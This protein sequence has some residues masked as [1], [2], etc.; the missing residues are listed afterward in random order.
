MFS[1]KMKS[2]TMIAKLVLALA[3]TSVLTGCSQEELALDDHYVPSTHYERYPIK[4]AK[5]PIKMEISSKFGSLQPSQINAISEFARS[6][7]SASASRIMVRRP[8]G[9]GASSQVA[10]QVAQLLATSGIPAS[11]ISYGTYP[12]SAKGPVQISYVRAVAVTKECGDW[13]SDVTNL[14]NDQLV[15]NLGCAIQNNYAAMVDN[16]EDFVVPRAT[17]PSAAGARTQAVRLY[18]P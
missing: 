13:S 14:P 11:Q 12:G 18:N 9:G 17:T 2:A 3:A 4:V 1:A 6:A 5:A 8:S 7:R 15:S 10:H 16:P